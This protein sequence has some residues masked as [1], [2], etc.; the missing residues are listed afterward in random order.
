[1]AEDY[2]SEKQRANLMIYKMI[3]NARKTKTEISINRLI[4]DVTNTFKIGEGTII[5][6]IELIKECDGDFDIIDKTIVFKG[7]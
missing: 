5:K 1:M 6:R 2:Y 4:F 7:D 3:D